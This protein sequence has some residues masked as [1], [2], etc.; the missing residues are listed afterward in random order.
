MTESGTRFGHATYAWDAAKEEMR[1]VLGRRARAKTTIAYSELVARV[2]TI[3]FQ[4]DDYALHSMLGEISSEEDEQ[5]RGMLS[6]LVVHVDGD[7]MLQAP[8]SSN[9]PKTSAATPAIE[10]SAGCTTFSTCST[11]GRDEFGDSRQMPCSC[12][13]RGPV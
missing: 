6:V 2:H 5:G 4:P 7:K 13:L 12:C 10:R 3:G 1:K 9:S 8:A 11:S